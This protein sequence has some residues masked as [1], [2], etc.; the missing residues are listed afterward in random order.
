MMGLRDPEIR[1][2]EVI[3]RLHRI[4]DGWV[5]GLILVSEGVRRGIALQ[6]LEKSAPEEIVS[7]FGSE[8]FNKSKKELQIFL[9]KTAFLP[10]MTVKMAQELTG[11]PDSGSHLMALTRSNSF[12][13]RRHH[14]EPVY[15]YH[16]LFRS[17]LIYC[18]KDSFSTE[19]IADLRHRAALL[20]EESEQL[21][22]A[23]SLFAEEANWE[24]LIGLTLRRAPNLVAQGRSK[25]V[26]A[27][28][29]HFP[30]NKIES[31][32][33]LLY[34]KGVC[35]LPYSPAEARLSF[36]QAFHLFEKQSDETGIYLAWSAIVESIYYEWDDF[37]RLDQWID[38][39]NRRMRRHPS[40][41]SPGIEARAA[42]SMVIALV[43]RRFHPH[44][45]E[46][47]LNR[48]FELCQNTMDMNLLLQNYTSAGIY[49][50]MTGET[51]KLNMTV[52][53][54]KR[55]VQSSSA[56][57]LNLICWKFVETIYHENLAADPRLPIKAI[58]EGVEIA[59][60][61][62]VHVMDH[63]LFAH[64][65]YGSLSLGDLTKAEEFLRK[66]ATVVNPHQRNM[67]SHYHFL[68]GW[69][70][71]L[72][73]Q[74]SQADPNALKAMK[75]AAETGALFPEIVSRFLLARVFH[76]KGRYQEAL[77]QLNHIRSLVERHECYVFEYHLSL[78]EAQFALDQ[79]EEEKCIEA[80][81][82]GFAFGKKLGLKTMLF[83]WQPS[84]MARL[85]AIALEKG[86]EMDYVQE[87]I[88]IFRF[89][90]DH[91]SLGVE[92]WPWSL[93]IYTLGRFGIIKDG[94]PIRFSR[95]TKEK[96]VVMLKALIAL[97]G[98]EVREED[99]SD[100]LWPEADGD[101]A[102]HSFQMVLHRLRMLLGQPETLLFR[103][104]RLTLNQRYCWVDAW[105]FER[106]LGEADEKQG[107]EQAEMASE[108][109]KKAIRMYIGPFLS[110]EEEQPWVLF[111][112]ERLRSKFLRNVNWL[113][114][115]WEKAEKWDKVLECYQRGLEVDNLAE[116]LY[117]RQMV[118]HQKLGQIAEALSVYN[119]CKRSLSS[120]LGIDPSP[121]T[122]VL[123]Q[124][125][126]RNRGIGEKGNE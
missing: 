123:Y 32:P 33:W 124:S 2:K 96:P 86:I 9:M 50:V 113:G 77:D 54:T 27:W 121:E 56:T 23:A 64:G 5:A 76:R 1:S 38:W 10:M 39:F 6:S 26:E 61:H 71:L 92:N 31:I 110:G 15:Q 93:K 17:F 97:G 98:R 119:R 99:L 13:E 106:I 81:R 22:E 90:T 24:S 43:W 87:L 109:I 51:A 120:V 100:I 30:Q 59:N 126:R 118:C 62:G 11:L 63:M 40:F 36:E 103:D 7:Y 49:Y 42:T 16:P 85:C 65:A 29:S 18:A 108:L 37:A 14:T 52:E 53:E 57:P 44:D 28:L 79:G 111:L 35:R 34:W 55:T 82:R 45:I 115:H 88:R 107:R 73:N 91:F 25:T 78:T 112:R 102:H 101:A 84:E 80:L 4:T 72:R 21:E 58:S 48:A 94:K 8:L 12:I 3:E 46:K 19:M 60:R 66:M 116:E 125:L 41:P 69:C 20:L 74:I 114:R 95:K 47:W 70:Q 122:E 104:A 83:I 68:S 75:L 105:A 67:V 117:R 89:P